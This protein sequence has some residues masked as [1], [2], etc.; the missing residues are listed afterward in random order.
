MY[1]TGTRPLPPTHLFRTA[2]EPGVIAGD[3]DP[4]RYEPSLR[5]LPPVGP[6]IRG[7]PLL[8][9]RIYYL[10]LLRLLPRTLLVGYSLRIHDAFLRATSDARPWLSLNHS[11][12]YRIICR[13]SRLRC[14]R[15]D[16]GQSNKS[17][18]LR[19]S[20]EVLLATKLLSLSLSFGF[21]KQRRMQNC[22]SSQ[23]FKS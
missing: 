15:E 11:R 18:F 12:I 22:L 21:W 13:L 5:D 14:P 19:A 6:P 8:S 4:P 16:A 3:K 1:R 17:W 9:L 7:L 10:P 2:P 20:L 23:Y